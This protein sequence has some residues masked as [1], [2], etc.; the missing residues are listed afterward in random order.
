MLVIKMFL[1]KIKIN[2]YTLIL[3]FVALITGLFKEIAV[4]FILILV[5]EF[6]HFITM[7]KY[8]WNVKQIDIYPFGG[9]TKLDDKID[10][11]LKEE[12]I[13]TL[14][15]PVFQEILFLI[16]YLLYKRY[17]ISDYLFN[18][19]KNYNYTILIFNL[20]PIVPLDGYKILNV[21]IN[22]IFNFRYSY[23]IGIVLS[24]I[25]FILFMYMYK[26]DSSYYVILAF[27]I[28]QIIYAFKVRNII[29]NRFIL[30]KRLYKNEYPKLKK[31]NNV[32][33]MYR[34]KRHI[35]KDNSYK[36]EYSY[37]KRNRI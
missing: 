25:T 12:L 17:L 3:C 9:I 8:K 7:K 15:G 10:K 22:K 4:V 26:I 1:K 11:P 18:L 37:F 14:M 19:F 27:L 20:L 33:K 21:F 23:V 16:I 31:I 13:I 36:T 32:K 30:E 35:I 5:H 28:F 6:G 34:N 2:N 24:I 29:Y